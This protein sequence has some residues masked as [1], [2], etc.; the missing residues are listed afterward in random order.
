M[1][2]PPRN[3]TG[4]V[5][6]NTLCCQYIAFILCYAHIIPHDLSVVSE[7]MYECVHLTG[8]DMFYPPISIHLPVRM[9]V[10]VS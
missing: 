2:R 5:E 10:D 6:S 8:I 3:L 4:F 7:C 1:R 9:F